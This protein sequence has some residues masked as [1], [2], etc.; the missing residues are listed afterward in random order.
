M[1]NMRK[2]Y[3][4]IKLKRVVRNVKNAITPKPV[5]SKLGQALE[6]LAEEFPNDA[7]MCRTHRIRLIQTANAFGK[8]R[9]IQTTTAYAQAKQAYARIAGRAY[10][11]S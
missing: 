6:R 9:T 1:Q 2:D 7:A 11:E 3:A 4:M 10:V 5:E 8:T